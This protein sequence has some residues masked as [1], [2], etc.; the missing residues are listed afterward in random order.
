MHELRNVGVHVI[1]AI[2]LSIYSPIMI[3]IAVFMSNYS[4]PTKAKLYK[5]VLSFITSLLAIVVLVSQMGPSFEIWSLIIAI[6]ST[7]IAIGNTYYVFK[8]KV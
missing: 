7:L 2:V 5:T 3:A 8:H 1:I 4:K 6:T